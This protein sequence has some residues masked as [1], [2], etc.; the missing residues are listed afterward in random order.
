[1]HGPGIAAIGRHA[2]RGYGHLA[3]CSPVGTLERLDLSR[4]AQLLAVDDVP[5]TLEAGL[6]QALMA[7]YQAQQ[8]C[9]GMLLIASRAAPTQI[10]CEL[11]DIASRLRGAETYAVTPLDETQVRRLLVR[12]ARERG[13]QLSGPVVDYWLTRRARSIDSLLSDLDRLDQAAWRDQRRLTV[14]FMKSVL[15]L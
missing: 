4:P 5:L 10:R 15:E 3:D 8:A 7:A 11:A 12:R 14:P 1:M 13:L 2:Q 6:E 9:G